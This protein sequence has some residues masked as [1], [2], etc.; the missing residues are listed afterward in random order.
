MYG[1][2]IGTITVLIRFYTGY[3]EG[4]TFAILLGN[5]FAPLIDEVIIRNRIG[6]YARER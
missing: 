5:I 3:V 6:R 1:V 2:L 4:V